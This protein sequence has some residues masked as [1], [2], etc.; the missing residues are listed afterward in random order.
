MHRKGR[1]ETGSSV[2]MGEVILYNLSGSVCNLYDTVLYAW[3]AYFYIP[4]ED[5]GRI[6]YLFPG[7]V[8]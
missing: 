4:P 5:M 3:V 2:S 8:G 1:R 7:G 6:Q